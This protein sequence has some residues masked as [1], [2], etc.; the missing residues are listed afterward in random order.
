MLHFCCLCKYPFL[1]SIFIIVTVGCHRMSKSGQE[2]KTAQRP[3]G[4]VLEKTIDGDVLGQRLSRPCGI[5]SDNT[6]NIFLVDSGNNRIL[7]LDRNLEP[8]REAGGFGG[9][10]G[11]LNSPTYL[12]IDNNLS[13]YVSDA[14]NQRISIFDSRL[15][16]VS[17]IDLV[18]P[19]DPL[20]FGR[21][22][23]V[24]INDY[25]ELWVADADNSRIP[26]FNSYGN[27][28]RFVGDVEAYSGLLLTP[29]GIERDNNGN[30]FVSDVGN[31]RL[32]KFNSFGVHLANIG[33]D[34][35]DKP[36]GIAIDWHG[37]IWVVDAGLPAVLCFD[38]KGNLL[39]SEGRYGKEGDYS[40]SQ[41]C[42]LTILPDGRIVVSDTGNSRLL[43]YRILYPE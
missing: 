24:M 2:S 11:L 29:T 25:G 19:D 43:I 8:V 33:E 12:A 27:F 13:L 23:G 1:F 32:I 7:K 4:I 42:D 36:S 6:G 14:G 41:P 39:Y 30:A 38:R 34:V 22:S 9:S 3:L 16:Y 31:S 10:E 18:D 17:K 26:V 20:K 28:D 21:P 35:L 37:N 15:H 40:L 5:V